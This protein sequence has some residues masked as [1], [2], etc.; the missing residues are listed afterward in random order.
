MN[1]PRLARAL[2]I[3]WATFCGIAAVL[4]YSLWLRSYT[5]FDEFHATTESRVTRV[6]SNDGRLQFSTEVDLGPGTLV[7]KWGVWTGA[8]AHNAIIPP[9]PNYSAMG[10]TVAT[11]GAEGPGFS[12]GVPSWFLVI[13]FA[14][15][16]AASWKRQPY[17][18]FSLRTLL[19]ATTVVVISLGLVVWSTKV[20]PM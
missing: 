4:L 7:K 6:D 3:T 1:R 18:R 17:W 2:R 14:A 5:F 20:S 11:S 16:A 9:M 19:I 8:A 12:I 13:T 15:L 10:F